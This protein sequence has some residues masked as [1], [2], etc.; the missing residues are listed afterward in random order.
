MQ[1][2]QSADPYGLVSGF[3]SK[4]PES[5]E[6]IQKELETIRQSAKTVQSIYQSST[7]Y[8]ARANELV[9]GPSNRGTYAVPYSSSLH[10]VALSVP[11]LDTAEF[12]EAQQAEEM[13]L[14]RK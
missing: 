6:A 1:V 2:Y 10:D 7:K 13:R 4:V 8:Q 14:L 3:M 5:M 11:L 12:K 9:S